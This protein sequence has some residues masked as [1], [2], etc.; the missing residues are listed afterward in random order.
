[1]MTNSCRVPVLTI[2]IVAVVCASQVFV[3]P[4]QPQENSRGRYTS[5][6]LS[7]RLEREIAFDH[8]LLMPQDHRWVLK[9]VI[10]FHLDGRRAAILIPGE[11][12]I[13][14]RPRT[15]SQLTERS[16]L[17][18]WLDLPT[19]RFLATRELSLTEREHFGFAMADTGDLLCVIAGQKVIILNETLSDVDWTHSELS[20]TPAVERIAFSCSFVPKSTS[21][22]VTYDSRIGPPYA[23]RSTLMLWNW[24]KKSSSLLHWDQFVVDAL[25][26]TENRV[27]IYRTI[28]DWAFRFRLEVMDLRSRDALWVGDIDGF[29]KSSLVLSDDLVLRA[30]WELNVG[31]ESPT[32]FE[33]PERFHDRNKVLQ[34]F[35]VRE[36]QQS[37]GGSESFILLEDRVVAWDRG[38]RRQVAEF[39]A[40]GLALQWPLCIARNANWFAVRAVD[41][42]RREDDFTLSWKSNQFMIFSLDGSK[43]RLYASE[44][45]GPDEAITGL[46]LSRDD[47][48]LLVATSSRLLIYSV[49]EYFSK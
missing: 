25:P 30:D 33:I 35:R 20:K 16:F 23:W 10:A 5:G 14:L 40:R 24:E 42:S 47:K 21:V 43:R 27:L 3:A 1:M 12:K 15:V 9:H 48:T 46:A 13:G 17:L 19:G 34:A 2:A 49:E 8:P 36:R 45:F 28:P 32:S 18:V 41:F 31:G 7:L 29:A 26:L 4:L 6:N 22:L 38:S 39:R 11:K 37:E 44:K